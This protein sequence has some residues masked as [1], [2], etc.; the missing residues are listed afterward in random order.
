M[1]IGLAQLLP[2]RTGH[3]WAVRR[4]HA[5]ERGH[6]ARGLVAGSHAAGG[7]DETVARQ[8]LGNATAAKR[9]TSSPGLA[10]V[11][12]CVGGWLELSIPRD[13]QSVKDHVVSVLPSDVFVAGTLRGNVTA[14][15][16]ATALEGISAVGPFA[17]TSIIQMPSP[18]D[19]R[20]ELK[21]SGHWDDFKIQASKGGS[22]RFQ[23]DD[24]AFDDPRSWVPIMLSPALG[25]PNGNTLQEFHYQSRCIQMVEAHEKTQRN[26]VQYNRVMFTRLEFEWLSN[27]PPLSALDSRYLWIPTGE[28]NTGINDRHWLAN[29]RDA[30]FVFR[31]WD[32]LLNGNYH[33]VFFAT[34]NVRPAFMSSE[35]YHKLHLQ[36]HEVGVARFP[37]VAML[38]CCSSNY[39]RAAT[40][41]KQMRCFAKA[42]HKVPC[43]RRGLD[44][45]DCRVGGPGDLAFKYAD[46]GYSAVVH[47]TALSLPGAALAASL[48]ATPPRLHIE[49]P[50]PG[51]SAGYLYT[52]K[53][54]EVADVADDVSINVTA[55]LFRKMTYA[56]PTLEAARKKHACRYFHRETLVAACASLGS[57]AVR[58]RFRWWC[59]DVAADIQR[60]EDTRV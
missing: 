8:P 14:D 45:P 50:R 9:R 28:D 51:G 55:C 52:C 57:P 53:T 6:T 54:C 4:G 35:T 40:A 39:D 37:S 38:Q 23:F 49:V 22:G 21:N 59:D 7:V 12:I 20:A 16:V 46:E 56:D 60:E 27:H 13:G 48:D 10:S 24:P 26:G 36:H 2:V 3:E 1:V 43:P 11:A 19:L 34:S 32:S 41:K 30:A 17:A 47:A 31:R 42:C 33:K 15:R 25:N 18:A 29:R 44:V 58:S 5:S